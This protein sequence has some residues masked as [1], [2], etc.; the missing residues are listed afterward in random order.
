MV[1]SAFTSLIFTGIVINHIQ[2]PLFLWVIFLLIRLKDDFF[3]LLL[4]IKNLPRPF[5]RRSP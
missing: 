5:Y 3:F 2:S 4:G 1:S